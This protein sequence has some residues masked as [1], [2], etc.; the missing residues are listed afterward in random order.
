MPSGAPEAVQ[1]HGPARVLRRSCGTRRSEVGFSG[2]GERLV[3]AALLC[4]PVV[5][6]S[7]VEW[8]A[9]F[10][11]GESWGWPGRPGRGGCPGPV[12]G[13][14]L[15]GSDGVDPGP[16]GVGLAGEV[17]GVVDPLTVEALMLQ[18]LG[19]AL[20]LGHGCGRD[21]ARGGR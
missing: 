13:R 1:S 19:G 4:C 10:R 3:Q 15:V 6:L 20:G 12:P 7:C 2:S 18:R 8:L 16:V 14:R 11:G 9:G 17:E 5:A 21:P